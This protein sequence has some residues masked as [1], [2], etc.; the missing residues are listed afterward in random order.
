[1][2][3]L[4]DACVLLLCISLPSACQPRQSSTT[5]PI[6]EQL[7]GIAHI[8]AEPV[9]SGHWEAEANRWDQVSKRLNVLRVA[10]QLALT[11]KLLVPEFDV[12]G[13]GLD[14]LHVNDKHPCVE[15]IDLNNDGRL[16]M[17][18]SA[19][20]AGIRCS[21]YY[22]LIFIN[23]GRHLEPALRR[24]TGFANGLGL[25]QSGYRLVPGPDGKTL[26]F[27]TWETDLVDFYDDRTWK[28]TEF[29]YALDWQGH[30]QLESPI[31]YEKVG[32]KRPVTAPRTR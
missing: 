19:Y 18:L 21:S 31:P 7:K 12:E 8:V 28:T 23:D 20:E 9:A 29:V 2:R 10:G 3:R 1:M 5:D 14:L 25:P 4:S 27:H 24:S 30:Y 13:E 22:F 26:L 16:D 17:I 6:S 15:I 11:N 32:L